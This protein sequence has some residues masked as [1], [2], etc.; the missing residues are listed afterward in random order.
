M[1]EV[2]NMPEGGNIV[3]TVLKVDLSECES[4]DKRYIEGIRYL[5]SYIRDTV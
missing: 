4:L 2:F 1:S 5:K 3:K